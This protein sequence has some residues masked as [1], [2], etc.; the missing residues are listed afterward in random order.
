MVDKV[1]ET[2]DIDVF[3]CGRS[4][5]GV[6]PALSQCLNCLVRHLQGRDELDELD[7]IDDIDEID[8]IDKI[9]ETDEIDVKV[10]GR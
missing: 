6:P 2:D 8:E 3:V 1:D 9:D 5:S 7:E 4:R 10:C